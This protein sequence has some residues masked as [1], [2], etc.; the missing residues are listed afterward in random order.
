MPQ[1]A[2]LVCV[3]SAAMLTASAANED[4]YAGAMLARTNLH[5]A[6]P[7]SSD[8]ERTKLGL[9]AV[10]GYRF[11][12]WFAIEGGVSQYGKTSKDLFVNCVELVG[13]ACPFEASVST[14][15]FSVSA[16]GSIPIRLVDIFV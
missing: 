8:H 13:A 10:G 2:A 7:Y 15:A 9:S 6:W 5:H 3:V 12:R 11:V 4:A 1:T 14:D 16:V